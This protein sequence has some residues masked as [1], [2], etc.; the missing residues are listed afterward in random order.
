[1]IKRPLNASDG[2]TPSFTKKPRPPGAFSESSDPA[3][4]GEDS[5][6]GQLGLELDDDTAPSPDYTM[7]LGPAG[8]VTIGSPASD[9]SASD[10]LSAST[11]SASN[12]LQQAILAD[13]PTF[14]SGAT[15]SF[16]NVDPF[17]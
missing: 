13:A 12:I 7:F 2:A 9:T 17:S 5:A 14:G 1:M 8:T 16:V 3:G 6:S 11:A 4:T 15:T 10:G